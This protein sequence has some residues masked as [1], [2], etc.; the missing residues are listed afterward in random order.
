MRALKEVVH[1]VRHFPGVTALSVLTIAL[2]LYISGLFGMFYINIARALSNA[3][4]RVQMVVFLHDDAP[5]EDISSL[6]E[7]L[8]AWPGVVEVLFTS[9]E[10]A[11]A[12]FRDELGDNDYLLD[13]LD[14]NP[15]PSSIEIQFDADHRNTDTLQTLAEEI[16]GRAAVELVDYAKPW[17]EKLDRARKII[18][19]IGILTGVIVLVAAIFLISFSIGLAMKSKEEEM[20]IAHLIGATDLYIS[21][22]YLVEG[23]L[24]G[25]IGGGIAV[26]LLTMTRKLIVTGLYPVVFFSSAQMVVAV[27]A[28]GIIGMIGAAFSVRHFLKT[29]LLVCL[30]LCASGVGRLPLYGQSKPKEELGKE[31][32]EGQSELERIRAE[33]QKQETEAEKLK[34]K[35][36]SVSGEIQNLDRSIDLKTRLVSELGKELKTEEKELG[37]IVV[38]LKEAQS[39]LERRKSVLSKRLRMVYERGILSPLEILLDSGS[40]P[41]LGLRLEYLG[42]V[43]AYDRDLVEK[44]SVL[45]EEIVSNEQ[46]QEMRVK[47]I[48][49]RRKEVDTEKRSLESTSAKKKQLL[50][51]VRTEKSKRE[52][53]IKELKEQQ[54]KLQVLLEKLEQERI[55]AERSG[56]RGGSFIEKSAGKLPWP[57]KGNVITKF[58]T[59]YNSIYKTRIPSQ[60]IDIQA[61][62][63]TTVK[64][65]GTGTIEYA[66][67]WQTYGKMIIINHGG[68]YYTIYTHLNDLYVSIGSEVREGQDIG[69]VGKTGSLKGPYLHFELRQGKEALD[70]LKWLRSS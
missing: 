10:E 26:L 56:P 19:L 14:G 65:V 41:R 49:G 45:E 16:E 47:K 4:E 27:C 35:E 55:L 18:G 11:L 46:D 33:L 32:E 37:I 53:A 58:G 54:Q 13:N 63:G 30:M 17:T 22:P 8:A 40:L 70:P 68:G 62:L 31:I 34:N 15:L 36:K 42:R 67:W 52:K 64:A 1:N 3:G 20:G 43:L 61:K 9:K 39:E 38:Q 7:E 69:T 59:N 60:G 48:S 51:S 44:I 57:V 2:T 5:P 24:K 12:R 6:R 21:R 29:L 23:L 66:D 50:S 25:L 28:G